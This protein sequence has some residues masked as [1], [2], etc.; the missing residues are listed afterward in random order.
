LSGGSTG[1]FQKKIN[2]LSLRP[3]KTILAD[4]PECPEIRKKINYDNEFS[5]HGLQLRFEWIDRLLQI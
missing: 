5:F 4:T 3:G 1:W 2:L